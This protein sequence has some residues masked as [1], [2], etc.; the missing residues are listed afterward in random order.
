MPPT[1]TPPNL[2]DR[3]H[4]PLRRF[5]INVTDNAPSSDASATSA[6]WRSKLHEVIFEADT[7]AGKA[8][9]VALLIAILVSMLAVSLETVAPI[10]R[11][12]GNLLVAIEWTITILF[13]LEYV[14][15]L[16]CV[17]S[18]L[19]YAKSF[20]GTL[21]APPIAQSNLCASKALRSVTVCKP[22]RLA[23]TPFSST[24]SPLSMDS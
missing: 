23:F 19:R 12:Y 3:H 4:P 20:F 22:L 11:R 2:R 7:P 16:V 18:P 13:T 6:P 9:D 21:R 14:L 24:T 8:F 15:R 5:G 1:P 10:Q 17:G